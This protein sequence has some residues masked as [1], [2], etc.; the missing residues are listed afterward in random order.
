MKFD[1][2]CSIDSPEAFDEISQLSAVPRIMECH[3]PYLENLDYLG[4]LGR[5]GVSDV[6]VPSEYQRAVVDERVTDNVVTHV[7]PNPIGAQFC[8]TILDEQVK[9]ARPVVAWVGRLDQLKNWRGYLEV[10]SRL[11]ERGVEFEGWM[12]GDYPRPG[13]WPDLYRAAR[14]LGVLHRLRWYKGVA[15]HKLPGWFDLVRESGGVFLCTSR[16]DS[17]GMTLAEAMARACPVIAPRRGPYTE[18]IEH[19]LTG[20]LYEGPP[21]AASLVEQGISIESDRQGMGQTGRAEMLKRHAPK[22]AMR[23]LAS[24]LTSTVAA[25]RGGEI[26]LTVTSQGTGVAGR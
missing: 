4:S 26:K 14:E 23:R 5:F 20:Y 1:L 6:L 7:V 19:G 3:S 8:E 21:Q 16:G 11:E 17:F 22:L 2:I 24:V 12:A 18:F 25:K 10:L 13:G 15:H 9:P